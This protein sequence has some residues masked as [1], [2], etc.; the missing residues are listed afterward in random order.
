LVGGNWSGAGRVEIFHNGTWGTVCDDYWDIKDARVVCRELGYP[1]AVSAPQSA[2]FGRG[3]GPIWLDDVFCSGNERSIVGCV[4]N[5]WGV[6]NC[7]HSEDASVF[8]SIEYHLDTD[9]R[10]THRPGVNEP[11]GWVQPSPRV[12]KQA[13]SSN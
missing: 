9:L 11:G 6:E 2:H 4:H 13:N 3:S 8:C 1:D 5:G 7:G 12:N 10:I